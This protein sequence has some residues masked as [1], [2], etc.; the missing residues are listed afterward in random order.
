ML[1]EESGLLTHQFDDTE[2]SSEPWI[3][4]GDQLSCSLINMGSPAMYQSAYA[5]GFI[6]APSNRVLC[7][8]TRD[9]ATASRGDGGCSSWG[10][11]ACT[12]SV[13]WNCIWEGPWGVEGML[14]ASTARFAR[15]GYGGNGKAYNEVMIDTNHYTS[16]MPQT[17]EAFFAPA[18]GNI[19]H[20]ATIH[21]QF[22]EHF[23]LTSVEVPLL[24]FDP[25]RDAERP[26]RRHDTTGR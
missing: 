12:Q 22:L 15:E 4:L 14:T 3:P 13:D 23:G 18:G 24:I 2:I 17:L 10:L 19:E 6:L 9:G 20:A 8:Y 25:A 26:W 11:A 21:A 16:N 7:S 5:S 1:L